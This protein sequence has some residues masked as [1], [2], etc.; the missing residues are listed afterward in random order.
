[1]TARRRVVVIGGGISGLATA[2]LLAR[3]GDDVTLV[4]AR[5]EL[6]G[7]AGRWSSD[8]FVFDTGPSWYLMPEVFDHFFRLLGTSAA[9]QLDLVRLDPAYRVYFE[10]EPEPFDLPGSDARDA[11]VSL[12][13]A[14]A[15]R[16]DAYLASAAETY[17]LATSKFLYSTYESLRPL[18]GRDTLAR[19]PRL[20]RLLGEPLDRF[21]RRHTDDV[22]VQQVLGYPAVFLGT[23]PAAAPSMYH[24]MSHLDVGQGVLYP[25]GG[26]GAVIDAIARLA[27]SHGAELRT[28]TRARRIS[29][30]GGV[31]TAVDVERAD[32]TVEHL[33]ADVVV[34]SADLH[35]TEQRLLAP[36]HRSRRESWWESR[37]PGPG[38]VLALL[39]VRGELPELAHHTLFFTRDWER[40]FDAIYGSRPHIPDPASI[41]VCR[42]SATDDVAPEGHENL[43]VLI[44]VPADPGIGEGGLDGGGSPAVERAVDA[45]IDQVASWAGVPDLRERIVVRRSIGPADFEREY[46]AWRGG[47]LGPAHTLRQSAV[48]RG[49]NASSR[50]G[51]LLYAG[52]TTIPGIGLPMCLIS[53]ELV[54]KRLR[55]DLSAGPL[56]EPR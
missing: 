28:G 17:D 7:R 19:L 13:P 24:L 33:S 11:L 47:A 37:D 50:V 25:R 18:L 32:G 31:A 56:E 44:P 42:P 46:G 15:D 49:S 41:Y 12:D 40:G 3:E 16:L 52:A 6:G 20:A 23:S 54:V 1:M 39:G 27:E 36:E 5:D 10:A 55:G 51:G 4:E 34:S 8:G 45:A 53:A 21:I 22:R 43:F 14:A 38:A 29:V 48:L 2:A 30:R 9:E 26:F 35:V